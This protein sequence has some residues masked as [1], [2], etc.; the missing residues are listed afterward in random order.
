VQSAGFAE[1]RNPDDPDA[2]NLCGGLTA[3]GERQG[4][5][6]YAS[7][8]RNSSAGVPFFHGVSTG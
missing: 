7:T 5:E 4:K 2:R 1:R 8:P 3:S 6:R